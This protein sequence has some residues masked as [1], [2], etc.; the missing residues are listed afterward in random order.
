M[1]YRDSYEAEDDADSEDDF[2]DPENPD[3]SDM[4]EDGGDEAALL[5]CPWC[6]AEV[7]E[8]A[9]RCPQCGKYLSEEDAPS[10]KPAWIAVVAAV[11]IVV[12]LV[13]W[14]LWGG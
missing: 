7:A 1:A 6:R 12:I 8:G 10:R 5:E 9:A 3:P 14:V 2:D 13:S 4:D 11:L